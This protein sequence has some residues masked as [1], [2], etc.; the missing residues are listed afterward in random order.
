[1]VGCKQ[2]RRLLP[3]HVPAPFKVTLLL[4]PGGGVYF[5]PLVLATWLAWADGYQHK[6]CGQGLE[7]PRMMGLADHADVG[8]LRPQWEEAQ[9]GGRKR[10]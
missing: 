2:G 8:A 10:Y 9:A 1:M 3:P 6:W 7:R 4:P 5:H